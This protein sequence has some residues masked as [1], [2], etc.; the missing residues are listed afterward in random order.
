MLE[1]ATEETI[2][3]KI[4]NSDHDFFTNAEYYI[5]EKEPGTYQHKK[6]KK[7]IS[8]AEFELIPWNIPKGGDLNA[9]NPLKS[10]YK[11]VRSRDDE[12]YDETVETVE[13]DNDGD[14]RDACLTLHFKP[15]DLF[16]KLEG[17]YSSY[18]GT[19]YDTVYVAETYKY[20]ETRYRRITDGS[21]KK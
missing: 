17:R 13:E 9:N 11:Y 19:E 5:G 10:V 7:I 16:V 4:E 14:G 21:K 6:T 18:D 20:T 8:F 15:Y 2:L 3:Q 1:L 12:F